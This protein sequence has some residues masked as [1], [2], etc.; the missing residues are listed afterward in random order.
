MT[1][2]QVHA[3]RIIEGKNFFFLI[4]NWNGVEGSA[5]GIYYG[6]VPLFPWG[7]GKLQNALARIADLTVRFEV[8]T[9]NMN[10]E[11]LLVVIREMCIVDLEGGGS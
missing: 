9:V 8:R 3:L 5:H 11:C 6:S 2:F 4:L 7:W 1:L 10:Q